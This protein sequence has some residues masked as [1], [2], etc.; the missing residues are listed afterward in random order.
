MSIYYYEP[1]STVQS[2]HIKHESNYVGTGVQRLQDIIK[3]ISYKNGHQRKYVGS[4]NEHWRQQVNNDVL[5]SDPVTSQSDF[6]STFSLC[7]IS[8]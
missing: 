3:T 6:S 4:I 2:L 5:G 1:V 8:Y 7:C